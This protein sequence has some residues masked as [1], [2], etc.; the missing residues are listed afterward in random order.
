MIKTSERLNPYPVGSTWC[1]NRRSIVLESCSATACLADKAKE[2]VKRELAT[3]VGE[4]IDVAT[5][6]VP[7][8]RFIFSKLLSRNPITEA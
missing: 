6:F 5:V 1:I 3:A 2:E 7:S 4:C 8:S